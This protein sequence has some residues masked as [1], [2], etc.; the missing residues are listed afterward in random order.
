ME[1]LIFER[2]SVL[3][4]KGYQYFQVFYDM[5][6]KV[7]LKCVEEILMCSMYCYHNDLLQIRNF[8]S[9]LQKRLYFTLFLCS[10]R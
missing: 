2:R 3:E 8:Y 6:K 10:L 4:N 5:V 7:N 1:I 9:D